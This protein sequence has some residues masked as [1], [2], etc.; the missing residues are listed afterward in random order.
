M[1]MRSEAALQRCG[2]FVTALR[3]CHVF[4]LNTPTRMHSSTLASLW[5]AHVATIAALHASNAGPLPSAEGTSV[6]VPGPAVLAGYIATPNLPPDAWGAV[7]LAALAA[8][9]YSFM[10]WARLRCVSRAWRD[11]LKG[12]H[13]VPSRR[14][15]LPSHSAPFIQSHCHALHMVT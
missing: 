11:G 4:A 13:T 14:V 9:D 15:V 1:L 2:E 6:P 3:P 5:L 10:A 8:E 12:A 7:A